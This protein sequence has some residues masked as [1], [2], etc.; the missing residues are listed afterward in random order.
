MCVQL[1]PT[2]CDTLHYS[3]PGSSVHE[4]FQ[5]RIKKWV[6]FSSFRGSSRPIDWTP[7]ASVSCIAGRF[8]TT[9]VSGKPYIVIYR[10]VYLYMGFPGGT[11]V[12]NP[13]ANAGN[14]RDV[15]SISGSGRS[16]GV[17]NG[18][19]LQYSCWKIPWTEELG[20]LQSKWLQSRT[21]LSTHV[22]K[23]IYICNICL[24][25]YVVYTYKANRIFIKMEMVLL[26]ITFSDVFVVLKLILEIFLS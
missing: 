24:Y 26:F 2:L 12:K 5:A 11:M 25:I 20:G 13:P 22:H 18:N 17:G 14:R 3:P 16:L 9:K 15:A 19:P 4:I 1:C 23:H 8:F 6:A 7:L 21:W 10:V